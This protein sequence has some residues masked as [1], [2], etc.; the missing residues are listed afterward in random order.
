MREIVIDKVTI[1]LRGVFT[2]QRSLE[3]AMEAIVMRRLAEPKRSAGETDC[4][5]YDTPAEQK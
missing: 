5:Q 1:H 2:G 3:D 4:Q